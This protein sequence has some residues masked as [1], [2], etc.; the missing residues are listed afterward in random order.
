MANQVVS[1]AYYVS[2]ARR[3]GATREQVVAE[4]AEYHDLLPRFVNL[5]QARTAWEDMFDPDDALVPLSEIDVP[6]TDY[7]DIAEQLFNGVSFRDVRLSLVAA[8]PPPPTHAPYFPR[9]LA[10]IPND[11]RTKAAVEASIDRVK[12]VLA[13]GG[14]TTSRVNGL[15]VGR[16]QSGKT[17]NYIG[18]MLKAMDEGWNV[19][20]VLTSCNTFLAKQTRDRIVRE[21][22][23]VGANNPQFAHELNFMTS[24]PANRLAGEELNNGF[25]YWGVS[26]KEVHGLESIRRWLETPSQP[27]SSMRVLIVDDESDN[28]SP[29]SNAGGAG[30]LDDEG[31]VERID[32]IRHESRFENLADW[33]ESLLEREWPDIDANTHEAAVLR[34][35]NDELT[36]NRSSRQKMEAIINDG[37]FRHLL[38]ME[39]FFDPPVESLIPA[40]YNHQGAGEDSYGGFVLLLRSILDFARERS[41]IN[42]A[43]CRLVGPDPKTGEYAYPFLQCCYL[44]YT[45]TPYAN[46]LNEGPSQTPIYADFIQ[47]LDI[48]PQ[49]FGAEAIFGEDLDNPLPRMPIVNA[50]TDDECVKILSPLRSERLIL[51]DD[52]VGRVKAAN[53]A[54]ERQDWTSL[55]A[56]LAWAFCTAAARRHARRSLTGDAREKIDNRWTT[57]LVNVDH[58]QPSHAVVQTSLER[59]LE[60]RLATPE[61]RADVR[62]ACED[63]WREQTAQ[64]PAQA[65]D[66]LFNSD[67]DPAHRYGSFA[68]YPAWEDIRDDL[69][70]F[71]ENAARHVHVVVMNCTNEGLETKKLYNQDRDELANHE[72]MELRD[73]H[74]WIVSGGNTISRGLTLLGLTTCYF[75]RLRT[76]TCVDTVTQMGRWFGY[77][78]GYELLP[79]IWMNAATVGEMKRI[80]VLEKKL[81]ASIAH[82]FA[83]HFSPAD[84]SHYQQISSWGR[85]L[86]GRAFASRNLDASIGT[87]A[88]TTEFFRDAANR[89][90]IVDEC[91]AF[92]SRCGSPVARDPSVYTYTSV[93]LWENVPRSEIQRFLERLLPLYPDK[94]RRIL[95]GI[96][97]ETSADVRNDEWN[98]VVGDPKGSGHGDS[99]PLGLPVGWATPRA[100]PVNPDVIQ[101]SSR[102]QLAFYAMIKSKHLYLTDLKYLQ[103]NRQGVFNALDRIRIQNGGTLPARYDAALPALCDAALPER[104]DEETLRARFDKLIDELSKATVARSL[105]TPIHSLLGNLVRGVGN[106]SSAEYMAEVHRSAPQNKPTLQLL[107]VR[108]DGEPQDETPYLCVSFYWPNHD[109]TGFFTVAVDEN[110]D[111]VTMVTRRG[112]C[113]TVEDILRQHDFPMQRRALECKVLERLGARCTHDF[114]EQNV[115]NPLE[116]YAYHRMAGR[117]AYCINGWAVDDE[118][119]LDAAF[120]TAAVDVLRRERNAIASQDLLDRVVAEQPKFRDFFTRHADLDAL[121]TD[122]VLQSNDIEVT[123]RR[124]ITYRY[125]GC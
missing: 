6:Q 16:V 86:S 7:L 124:P 66:E 122:D 9:Y 61:S 73:D 57:M 62:R 95:R 64:F 120:A 1:L 68:D 102:L 26:M 125:R 75:D 88:A 12:E 110:P 51:D 92:L 17:R 67:P 118:A 89:R 117:N 34:R 46:I 3:N 105:P 41:A 114:F 2:R 113:Q 84:P 93:P 21:F 59:Y 76:G 109:P 32:G 79:R 48:S 33:F 37:E 85:Q 8:P 13:T 43:L 30:V 35:M 39:Q 121:L 107:Q 55:K 98:V 101:F 42:A 45:A 97:R 44:G 119:R 116:G 111:F 31:I 70:F 78:P 24:N 82:N 28:A 47:S 60:L 23:Q 29:D 20:F 65:F 25:V 4:G 38:G 5:G 54:S 72:V 11:H 63:A 80:A 18:L 71:L 22:G 87:I 53:G 40:F 56:A 123:S 106:R 58:K 52:L 27:L 112:F 108:P 115:A 50:I 103:A 83:Q 96:L 94:S 15:I 81:H 14:V 74:L 49:Y 10:T 90:Q 100:I 91:R 69:D 104:S 77:R 36:S 19:I 99:Q